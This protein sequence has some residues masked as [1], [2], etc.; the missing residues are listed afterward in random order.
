LK[1]NQNHNLAIVGKIPSGLVQPSLPE[2][3]LFSKVIKDAIIIAIIAFASSLSV[4]D[5]YARKHKYA[6]DSNKEI[7]ALGMSNVVS[8]F[9]SSF[10]SCG[11]LARTVVL[12]SSGGRSQVIIYIFYYLL[13]LFN[14]F[15]I[16]L[17]TLIASGIILAVLLWISPLL[18]MLPKACL[19]SIIIAAV[20][21][22]FK[23][24]SDIKYYWKLDKN[25][26]V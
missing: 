4:A 6:I 2:F 15:Q 8:S 16:K 9:F 21:N 22:L 5:L 20:I 1:L 17:V 23:Q 14:I 26:F 24:F 12:E 25:E 10:V 7:F 3:N 18:E 19:G 11:A 13:F